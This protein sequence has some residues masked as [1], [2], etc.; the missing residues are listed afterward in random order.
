VSVFEVMAQSGGRKFRAGLPPF[1]GWRG[2]TR[3]DR[4]VAALGVVTWSEMRESKAKGK[5]DSRTRQK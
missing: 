4:P 1:E 2:C 3:Y 5:A